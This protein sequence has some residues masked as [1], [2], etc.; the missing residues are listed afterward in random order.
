[1]FRAEIS[2]TASS[3]HILRH[4]CR[5]DSCFNWFRRF[6][7]YRS[8]HSIRK[9]GINL[10]GICSM[11]ENIISS[12]RL[13]ILRENSLTL[14]HFLISIFISDHSNLYKVYCLHLYDTLSG[15]N[16][17]D[18]EHIFGKLFWLHYSNNVAELCICIIGKDII[19]LH[20]LFFG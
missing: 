13:C 14:L 2:F 7:V 1:M 16:I 18:I 17:Q 12:I 11:T 10:S 19:S 5:T 6:V 9:C 15:K 8:S 3:K 4:V 20:N